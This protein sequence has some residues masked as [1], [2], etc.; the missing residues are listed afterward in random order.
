MRLLLRELD[1]NQQMI[2]AA[3]QTAEEVRLL[4][5]TQRGPAHELLQAARKLGHWQVVRE[6]EL[7][8]EEAQGGYLAQSRREASFGYNPHELV[9]RESLALHRNQFVN[10]FYVGSETVLQAKRTNRSNRTITNSN[11]IM[12][13]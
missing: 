2:D 1:A 3:G 9:P 4:Q 13:D 7:I 5:L 11:R 12:K 6:F 8:R 10:Q